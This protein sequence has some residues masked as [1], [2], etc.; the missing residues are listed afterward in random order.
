MSLQPLL[1]TFVNQIDKLIVFG[2]LCYNPAYLL[3]KQFQLK[4]F[5]L[6]VIDYRKNYTVNEKKIEITQKKPR[7]INNSTTISNINNTL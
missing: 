5:L 6:Q 1:L 3:P 2:C 4:I 7:K